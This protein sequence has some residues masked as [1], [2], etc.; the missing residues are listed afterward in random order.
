[1]NEEE[2]KAIE[3]VENL[4]KRC[5]ECK[6]KE[7]INCETN[8]TEV[9]SIKR[10]VDSYKKVLKELKDLQEYKRIS[11][12]TKISCCTAQNCE[13]LN[14]A[15]KGELENQK[16]RQEN[17]ELKEKKKN[18]EP[19]LIGN[20]MYFIDKGLYEDLLNDI[21]SNYIPIQKITDKTEKLNKEIKNAE[22]IEAVFKIK[23]QQALQELLEESE[24]DNGE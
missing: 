23:Q 21:K 2:K 13:A 1:M 15:I 16:L 24:E 9:T 10:I 12:L 11:E 8:W 14:T 19:V 17:E 5:D 7:C 4:I 3:E 18:I 20:K 6:L 22:T